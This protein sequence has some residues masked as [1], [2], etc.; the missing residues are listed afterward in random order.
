M[1]PDYRPHHEP[2]AMSS[3]DL[4]ACY[5]LAGRLRQREVAP[6][7]DMHLEL[8]MGSARREL[9]SRGQLD[10]IREW[11]PV[12]FDPTRKNPLSGHGAKLVSQAAIERAIAPR[13]LKSAG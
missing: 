8:W 13:A 5:A 11:L 2:E 10:Q 6:S 4:A 9:E 1:W 12:T 7:L 3:D